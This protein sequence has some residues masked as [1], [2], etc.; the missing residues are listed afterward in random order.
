MGLLAVGSL[1]IIGVFAKSLVDLVAIATLLSFLTAPALAFLN[2][3]AMFAP[4]VPADYRPGR[5]MRAFSLAG[6]AF[7]TLVALYYVYAVLQ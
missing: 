2:H 3:R 7:N 1:V 6:V 5:G 4:E